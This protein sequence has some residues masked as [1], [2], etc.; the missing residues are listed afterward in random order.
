MNMDLNPHFSYDSVNNAAT[1]CGH[2]KKFIYWTYEENLFIKG[3][4]IYDNTDRCSK[5]YLCENEL[6]LL[7]LL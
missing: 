5:Q 2:M 7:S 1:I 3:S 6:C 4:I